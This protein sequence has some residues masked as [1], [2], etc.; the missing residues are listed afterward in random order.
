M[1]MDMDMDVDVDVDMDMDMDMDIRTARPS[2]F[3]H[4]VRTVRGAS[5]Q[6]ALSRRHVQYGGPGTYVSA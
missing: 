4:P 6:A 3:A 1:D 5:G 2:W